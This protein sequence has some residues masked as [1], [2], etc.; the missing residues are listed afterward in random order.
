MAH[1]PWFREI[2][3]FTSGFGG[4]HTYRIPALVTTTS[5]SL[6]AL[7]TTSPSQIETYKSKALRDLMSTGSHRFSRT[8]RRTLSG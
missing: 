5:R 1:V 7:Q 3:L 6:L 2:E 8:E 4:Y